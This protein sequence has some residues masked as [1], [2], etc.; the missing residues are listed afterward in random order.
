MMFIR[1]RRMV[2]LINYA[3]KIWIQVKLDLIIVRGMRIMSTFSALE[4][5]IEHA[6]L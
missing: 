5:H 6:V 1:R 4:G 2:K 3:E